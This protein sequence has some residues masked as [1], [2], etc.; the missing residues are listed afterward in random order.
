MSNWIKGKLPYVEYRVDKNRPKVGVNFDRY[1]R[2]RFK[3]LGKLHVIVLGHWSAG[4]TEQEAYNKAEKYKANI[5]AGQG[6]Q[7]W[8]EEQEMQRAEAEAE[9]ERKKQEAASNITFGK[10][11]E[12]YN[13]A[14]Q[15]KTER[16]MLTEQ[17]HFT[18]WLK[19]VLEHLPMRQIKPFH[20]EKVKKNMFDAGK[21]PKT[22]QYCF[23]TFRQVWNT[24]RIKDL[25]SGDSPTRKVKLPRFDN[26][27]LRFLTPD[28]ADKLLKA[29]AEKSQQLH[30]MAL[31]SLHTGMRAGEI[32]KLTWGDVNLNNETLTIR[33]SKSGKTRYAYFTEAT[34]G[35]LESLY[36]GQA[37]D[38]PVFTS[39]FG[40][41]VTEVSNSFERVVKSTGLNEGVSDRR[42]KVTFHTLRHTFAS[43]LVQDGTDLYV[44]KELLGH[45]SI[46]LTERY[47]HLQPDGPKRAV[48]LFDQKGNQEQAQDQAKV[49]NLQQG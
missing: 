15:H 44:V 18:L 41:R 33:D 30:D 20:L 26:K 28:E 49:I 42:Q 34:R 47:S 2:V 14:Q 23:A 1:Y 7:N 17:S 5:K 4:W 36:N 29:L 24:A 40:E 27:R 35:M 12:K 46:Q 3:A 16:T 22:A 38:Q 21:S 19:P 25:V 37:P 9:A 48:K 32:F 8:K 10:F 13:K 31:L 45:H 43:W 39:R 11:W 6:P